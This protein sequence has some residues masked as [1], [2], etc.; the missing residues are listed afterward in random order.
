MRCRA[1]IT[2]K[3]APFVTYSNFPCGVDYVTGNLMDMRYL[4]FDH[5]V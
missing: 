2:V 1:E 3:Y 4:V 5:E